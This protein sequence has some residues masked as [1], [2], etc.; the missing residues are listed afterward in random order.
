VS[1]PEASLEQ[2]QALW[3]EGQRRLQDADPALRGALE[4]VVDALV[5]Q[6]RRRLGY[7]YRADDLAGHYLRE[8]TDWCLEVAIAAAPGVP[9]AWDLTTVAGAAFARALRGAEDYGGGRRLGGADQENEDNPPG[10]R[11]PR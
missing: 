7:S 8:G 3:A 1:E 6:L 5:D 11:R 9:D 10:P 4:R 2:V